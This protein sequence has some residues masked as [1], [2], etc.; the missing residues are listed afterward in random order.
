MQCGGSIGNV[1]ELSPAGTGWN[2][3]QLYYFLGCKLGYSPLDVVRDQAGNLYGVASGGPPVCDQNL[4]CGTVSKL[5]QTGQGWAET[6]F[7]DFP[8]GD[9]GWGPSSV[10]L[11]GSKLYGTTAEGGASNYGAIFEISP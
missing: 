6:A 8:G 3:A 10:T 5:S 9:A 7:H 2:M 1:F 11:V 4:G